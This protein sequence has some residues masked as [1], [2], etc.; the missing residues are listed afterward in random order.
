MTKS[1]DTKNITTIVKGILKR[2]YIDNLQV[3]IDL[4]AAWKRY[5]FERE[6]GET[7]AQT[8]LKITS[9][10]SPGFMDQARMTQEIMDTLG[11]EVSLD[12]SE[13]QTVISFCLGAEK[14]G[15]TIKAFRLW[16]NDDPYNSPKKHQIAQSP[17]II[18]KTWRSAFENVRGEHKTDE[19]RPEYQPYIVQE[20]AG[21]IK[22]NPVVRR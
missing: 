19:T 3:E 15:E 21:L 2:N 13:W 20:E 16:M 9:E 5:L 4:I 11:V 8:R 7:P 10:Y 12:S 6:D 1:T 17:L 22:G 18:K 14:R